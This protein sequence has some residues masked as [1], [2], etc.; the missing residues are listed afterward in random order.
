[1]SLYSFHNKC[2]TVVGAGAMLKMLWNVSPGRELGVSHII[3]HQTAG[4]ST[5]LQAPDKH[6]KG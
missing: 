6:L 4:M 5:K 2:Q 1:M 3:E